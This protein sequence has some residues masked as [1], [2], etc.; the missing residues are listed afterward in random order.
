MCTSIR[1]LFAFVF[2]IIWAAFESIISQSRCSLEPKSF[3][4][5]LCFLKS[6]LR[7]SEHLPARAPNFVDTRYACFSSDVYSWIMSVFY[8]DI[9]K[10]HETN[11][12][13]EKSNILFGIP[14]YIKQQ[15][16][17]N[18]KNLVK[19]YNHILFVIKNF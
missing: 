16:C 12:S 18:L 14:Q 2:S 6:L 3:L 15:R 13:A 5:G 9:I 19:L 17:K 11:L 7:V 1:I 8:L 4:R 10:Q